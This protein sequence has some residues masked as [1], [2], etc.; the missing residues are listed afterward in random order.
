METPNVAQLLQQ[1]DV[2]NQ[3]KD[4]DANIRYCLTELLQRRQPT[5]IVVYVEGGNVSS[6]MATDPDIEV[7]LYDHDNIL[8]GDAAPEVPDDS[9]LTEIG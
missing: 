1:L 9:L 5:T 6:I 2:P 7:I 3:K 8:A 4:H